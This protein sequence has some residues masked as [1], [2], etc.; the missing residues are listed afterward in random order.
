MKKKKILIVGGDPN[1]I[2]SEIIL[3]CWK[4]I[5]KSLRKRIYI[6]SSYSLIKQ[7]LKKLNYSD[8][9][10]KI[11]D[12]SANSK[13]DKLKIIDIDLNFKNPFNVPKKVSSKFILKSLDLA[14][15][16]LINNKAQAMINCAIDKDLLNLKHSGV[17]EYLAMKCKIM[18]KSEVMLIFNKKLSVCPITTHID[19]K[20]VPPSLKIS[21][22][23]K[24]IKK[25]DG[26]YRSTLKKRPKIGVLGLNPHNAEL[27]KYS[28]EE[29]IIKPA[30]K[31]LNRFKLDISGPFPSD[32]IFIEKYKNY[33]VIVGMYHDQVLTPF[34]SIFKYD[35]INITL[36]LKYLRVSPDHGTAKNLLG[37]K[38]ANSTSLLNCINF[39]NLHGK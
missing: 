13:L 14:H 11:S 30:I 4:K 10:I 39:I 15:N 2:N 22:L 35:A 36:G 28:E 12:I 26:W 7:Q 31:E 18:D 3:K 17:T 5:S 6:I 33:D 34:K 25:I 37:K 9:I 19:L 16:I 24:K 38:K 8:Q 1:S 20:Q 23:I 27:R 21:L 29:K 32:T